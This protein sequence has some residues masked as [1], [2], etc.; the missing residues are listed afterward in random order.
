MNV[1]EEQIKDNIEDILR[2][3]FDKAMEE[4]K[5]NKAPGIDE[6]PAELLKNFG[7]KAKDVLFKI[8]SSIYKTGQIPSDFTKCLIIPIPKKARAQTCEQYRTLSLISHASNVLTRI[9]MRRIE[10]KID[11]ILTDDQ[12]GFRRGMGTRETI[13]SLRQ[14]IDKMN[15]KGKTIFY[16]L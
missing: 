5:N 14:V 2:G 6:I 16:Y 15:R 12:F 11:E 10:T 7:E 9:I 13:L 4:L 3:E 1:N 8:I